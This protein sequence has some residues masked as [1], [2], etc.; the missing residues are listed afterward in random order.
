MKLKLSTTERDRV[1]WE[2]ITKN[3]DLYLCKGRIKAEGK[4][5]K[6][7][8]CFR[9]RSEGKGSAKTTVL[10]LHSKVTGKLIGFYGGRSKPFVKDRSE[11]EVSDYL[12]GSLAPNNFRWFL[13]DAHQR[14]GSVV[15]ADKNM[16]SGANAWN[17]SAREGL[18]QMEREAKKK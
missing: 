13:N 4:K 17:K 6:P 7:S 3:R 16:Q 15:S 12:N 2:G 1:N 9:A 14:P 8:F 11:A 5:A 18:R 10:E